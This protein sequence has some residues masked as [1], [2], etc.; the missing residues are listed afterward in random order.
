[1][2]PVNQTVHP[3]LPSRSSGESYPPSFKQM[4]SRYTESRNDGTRLNMMEGERERGIGRSRKQ[5]ETRENE[6]I[7]RRNDEGKDNH[8]TMGRKKE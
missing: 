1:M 3:P 4:V 8:A 2:R 6:L 7:R 5:R